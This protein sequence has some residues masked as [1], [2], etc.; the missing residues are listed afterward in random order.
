MDV[1]RIILK[2]LLDMVLSFIEEQMIPMNVPW[3]ICYF[4]G[5]DIHLPVDQV[6][7]WNTL[8]SWK[9]FIGLNSFIPQRLLYAVIQT[10]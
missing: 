5:T 9:D 10:L 8:V 3:V 6:I 4:K 7:V 2:A 1:L